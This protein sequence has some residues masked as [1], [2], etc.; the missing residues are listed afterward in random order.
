MTDWKQEVEAINRVQGDVKYDFVYVDEESFNRFRPTS[1][2]GVI[3]AF[4]DYK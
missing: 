3:E 4:I 2:R 1:F